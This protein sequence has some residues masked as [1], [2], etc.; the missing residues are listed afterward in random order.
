MMLMSQLFA[1]DFYSICVDQ[2]PCQYGNYQNWV[3]GRET[4]ISTLVFK[5]CPFQKVK[6]T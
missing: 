6:N 1:D 2:Q 3:M 5:L 4:I